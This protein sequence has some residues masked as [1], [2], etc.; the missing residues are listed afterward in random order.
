MKRFIAPNLML[1][2]STLL[3]AC[4]Q[5]QHA[6]MP[7]AAAPTGHSAPAGS[8]PSMGG[9][10]GAA[11]IGGPSAGIKEA[12]VTVSV[13]VGKDGTIQSAVVKKSS[14]Y[15]QFDAA[16]IEQTRHW[17]M[18][19]ATSDGGEAVDKWANFNV[20]FQLNEPTEAKPK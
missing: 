9:G 13:L 1:A 7:I 18:K 8:V 3:F 17:K 14:G 15:P 16:A 6:A 5:T 10:E 12:L 19:P 20:R 2:A 11:V 4:A